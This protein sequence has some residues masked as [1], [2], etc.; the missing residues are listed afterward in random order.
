MKAILAYGQA[1]QKRNSGLSQGIKA[2]LTVFQHG[3]EAMREGYNVR[4][5]ERIVTRAGVTIIRVK[6]IN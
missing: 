6:G 3:V 4:A 2:D 5:F 1:I